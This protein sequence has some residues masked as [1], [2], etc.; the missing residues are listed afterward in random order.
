VF[1]DKFAKRGIDLPAGLFSHRP[2]TAN[3]ADLRR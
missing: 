3:V 2:V 1:L